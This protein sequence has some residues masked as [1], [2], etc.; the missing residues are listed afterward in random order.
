MEVISG[1]TI[2]SASTSGSWAPS[3][4]TRRAQGQF[5]CEGDKLVEEALR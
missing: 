5:L 1:R 2:P 3:E 4:N